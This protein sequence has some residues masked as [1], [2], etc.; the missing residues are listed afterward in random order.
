MKHPL[1]TLLL[2]AFSPWL[3]ALDSGWLELEKGKTSDNGIT[4]KEVTETAQGQQLVTIAIPESQVRLNKDGIEELIIIG[5][6]THDQAQ[7]RPLLDVNYEWAKDYESGYYGLIITL[8]SISKMPIRFR[9]AE[10]TSTV[11]P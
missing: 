10:D 3:M 5:Q 9:F 6:R 2:L 11:N 7:E 1:I 4:V 8:P